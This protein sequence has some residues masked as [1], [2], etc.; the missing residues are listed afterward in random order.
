LLL[1]LQTFNK[2]ISEKQ[3]QLLALTQASDTIAQGLAL[4]GGT[5]MKGRVNEMKAKVTK[6]AEAV[7]QRLNATSDTILARS[8]TCSVCSYVR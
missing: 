5:A 1:F 2:E 3:T 6:L 8:V 4:E 7:R